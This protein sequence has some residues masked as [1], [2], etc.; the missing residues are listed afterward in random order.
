MLG[1]IITNKDRIFKTAISLF[2][3]KGFRGTSIRDIA[4]EMNISISNIYHHFGNKEGLLIAILEHSS[5]RLVKELK[6]V[7]ELDLPPREKLKR[8]V[9]TH[10]RLAGTFTE[11]TKIFFLDE[12]HLSK[13]GEK[14]NR[15]IQRQIY[16]FYQNVLQDLDEAGLIRC[17]SI[18]VLA[19]NIFG[20][21]NWQLRWYRPEGPL[22][23]DEIID[24]MFSF[25][26]NGVFGTA[27]QNQK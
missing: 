23:M 27:E 19:F 21:I 22:S 4:N 26:M 2:S 18:K 8:L 16:G 15:N 12:E 5:E 13:E 11:E 17:R 14:I 20:V 24:E 1:N 9:E 7:S 10:I 6:E 25:I 3:A